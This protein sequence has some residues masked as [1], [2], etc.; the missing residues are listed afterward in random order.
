MLKRV[1]IKPGRVINRP[2]KFPPGIALPP[3]FKTGKA[4]P[5][6]QTPLA[7]YKFDS[8]LLRAVRTAGGMAAEGREFVASLVRPGITT[9]DLDCELTDFYLKTKSVYPSPIN[10]MGF[11]KSLCSSVNDVMVHGIPDDRVLESGDLVSLDVSC[12]VGGVHGDNCTTVA[13]GGVDALDKSARNLLSKGRECFDGAVSVCGPGVPIQRIGQFVSR[14]CREHGL[15]TNRDFCGHGLGPY[16]HMQPLVLH[17]DNDEEE[18][19]RP[20]MVFTIEPIL[21][22]RSAESGTTWADGW[23]VPT[24][25]GSWTVQ[26][27][28][29][30]LITEHGH[31]V[32]TVC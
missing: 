16:M 21:S 14:Y 11:P 30:V 8:P 23:T 27:E 6:H 32:L 10:Y 22:E 12:F 19:M 15:D 24:K 13:C 2:I 18:V 29:T 5:T 26:F 20:G 3:Y 25:D 4:P 28:H 9:E 7:I 17:C 31:E 1:P